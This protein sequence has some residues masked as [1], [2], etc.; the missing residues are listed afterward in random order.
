MQV[1]GQLV[2]LLQLVEGD[3]HARCGDGV[4]GCHAAFGHQLLRL[5]GI[6]LVLDPAVR[7]ADDSVEHDR[8][9]RVVVSWSEAWLDRKLVVA[10]HLIL[11]P[12]QI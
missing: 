6:R 12:V 1:V 3:P 7:P 8:L 10:L 4:G 9:L 11:E 5:S 2:V